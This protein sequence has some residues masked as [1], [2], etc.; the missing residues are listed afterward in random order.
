MCGGG[1][2]GGEMYLVGVDA[3][4]VMAIATVV[5]VV[6]AGGD[7]DASLRRELESIPYEVEHNL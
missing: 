6:Q 1:M 2:Y 3:V 5:G 4:V 7:C